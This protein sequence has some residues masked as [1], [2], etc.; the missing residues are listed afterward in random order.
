MAP[1]HLCVESQ[2]QTPWAR[3][4]LHLM[5]PWVFCHR[6]ETNPAW[7][8]YAVPLTSRSLPRDRYSEL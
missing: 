4:A 7:P 8:V 3:V 6:P 5:Q 2:A 1:K